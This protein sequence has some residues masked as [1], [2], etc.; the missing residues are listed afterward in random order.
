[1]AQ[2]Y[3]NSNIP[4]PVTPDD[5]ADVPQHPP[6]PGPSREALLSVSIF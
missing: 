4:L 5:E 3:S 6:R 2:P 1:M